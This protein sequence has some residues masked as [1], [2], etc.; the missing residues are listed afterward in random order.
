MTIP[1][2][3]NLLIQGCLLHVPR[4]RHSVLSV[5]PRKTMKFSLNSKSVHFVF[6]SCLHYLHFIR[7]LFF[8]TFWKIL[9]GGRTVTYKNL[10][11]NRLKTSNTW[12]TTIH[13]KIR[14]WRALR[15]PLISPFPFTILP[16]PLCHIDFMV[17]TS[18]LFFLVYCPRMWP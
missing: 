1:N 14:K 3:C 12:G 17:V 5:V 6:Q 16:P 18:S 13:W 15:K 7:S 8:L 2:S 10:P 11:Q 4:P 9:G